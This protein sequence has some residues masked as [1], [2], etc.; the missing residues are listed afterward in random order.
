MKNRC[1]KIAGGDRRAARNKPILLGDAQGDNWRTA[2]A[3]SP[4][5]A[6][7]VRVVKPGSDSRRAKSKWKNLEGANNGE[8]LLCVM[9]EIRGSE[10]FASES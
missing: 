3:S 1:G 10:G 5:R 7:P 8:G 2:I 6:Q 4:P 9:R